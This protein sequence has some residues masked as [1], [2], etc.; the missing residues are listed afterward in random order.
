MVNNRAFWQHTPAEMMWH[1]R[2]FLLIFGS[3]AAAVLFGWVPLEAARS[4]WPL[5]DCTIV[6]GHV[7][8]DGD[9]TQGVLEATLV[10]ADGSFSPQNVRLCNPR[11]CISYDSF[12]DKQAWIDEHPVGETVKCFYNPDDPSDATLDTS[13]TWIV[14]A[15]LGVD[16]FC[17]AWVVH[18]IMFIRVNRDKMG[19]GAT[20]VESGGAATAATAVAHAGAA[21]QPQ[22]W[23]P[24]QQYPGAGGAPAFPPATA[25][26]GAYPPATGPGA[27]GVYPPPALAGRDAAQVGYSAFPPAG[28]GAPPSGGTLTLSVV[29]AARLKP[30]NN[31]TATVTIAGTSYTTGVCAGGGMTTASWPDARWDVPMSGSQLESTAVVAITSSNGSDM[32]SGTLALSLFKPHVPVDTWVA[33]SAGTV[34]ITGM[35]APA[36]APSSS[37]A[38]TAYPP[39]YPPAAV[40]TAA[41]QPAGAMPPFG[42]GATSAGGAPVPNYEASAPPG[43]V[44]TPATMG[45]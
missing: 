20:G 28:P 42:A 36:A 10:P 43:A 34:H 17:L 19:Q 41:Y 27:P 33:L 31:P 22:P 1:A 16:L 26:P 23:P 13:F 11:D 24:Q 21:A 45:L 35:F 44:N 5:A 39:A 6:S 18:C 37:A 3:G 38:G 9:V 4:S 14:W 32:G 40:A 30:G 7:S 29:G 25:T 12:D 15:V 8:R 2:I